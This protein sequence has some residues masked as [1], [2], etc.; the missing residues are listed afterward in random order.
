MQ[1][2]VTHFELLFIESEAAFR[3]GDLARAANALNTA[4]TKHVDLVT[5]SSIAHLSE[6]GGNVD[7]YRE[8]ITTYKN[9]NAN[10]SAATITLEK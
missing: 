7:D 8:I 5:P 3:S 9:E 6:T 10:E 1:L 2:I 4:I